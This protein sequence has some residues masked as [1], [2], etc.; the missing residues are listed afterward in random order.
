MAKMTVYVPAA[1]KARMD[2]AEGVNWSPLACRAFEA[3]LAELITAKGAK[4]MKE[5]IARLKASKA[6]TED[7][8]KLQGREAGK[9]WASN[10]AEAAELQRLEEWTEGD[11][12]VGWTWDDHL[13]AERDPNAAFGDGHHLAERI[14]GGTGENF[15][16]RDGEL[17]WANILGDR[18]AD[19]SFDAAF[20]VGFVEGALEVWG[21][22]KD[23]L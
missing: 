18:E 23:Q 15:G 1:L 17:F 9:T 22:V 7:K 2:Q 12:G 6:K 3:K 16:R 13:M 14:S 4:D 19:L 10:Q 8:A 20:L 21:Q 11:F 5:V